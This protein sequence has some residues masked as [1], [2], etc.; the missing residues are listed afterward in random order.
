MLLWLRFIII[1]RPVGDITGAKW[2][3]LL[4]R[5]VCVW[6]SHCEQWTRAAFKRIHDSVYPHESTDSVLLNAATSRQN[7]CQRVH[8]LEVFQRKFYPLFVPCVWLVA[9]GW[10][11]TVSVERTIVVETKACA[12]WIAISKQ[13]HTVRAPEYRF[14]GFKKTI[15]SFSQT[16]WSEPPI[17]A[18]SNGEISMQMKSRFEQKF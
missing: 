8:R 4:K 17:M 9:A 10:H 7:I 12:G 3:S 2:F 18:H 6:R 14:S 1:E 15:P 16:V 11:S 5:Q 13:S